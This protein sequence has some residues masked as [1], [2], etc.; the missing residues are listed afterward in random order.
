MENHNIKLFDQISSQWR[1]NIPK[2]NYIIAKEIIE[3]LHITKDQS[4]LDV[5]CGT[6]ILYPIIKDTNISK[7]I[8]VD[9]SEKMIKEFLQFY[10]NADVRLMNFE[11]KIKFEETF[12][13]IIIFNS[14]PHF[15]D[16]NSVFE[17]AY[18]NLKPHGKFII[19][20]C[21]TREDLKEHHK[22]IGYTSIDPI[23]K[24]DTLNKLCNKY[25]FKEMKIH[26][27]NYFYFCCKK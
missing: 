18:N 2:K 10:P 25:N 12:D 8:A 23:P 11:N 16:L 22:L 9:I 20:H 7:Y 21:R 4:I 19:A 27:I 14:I 17:N 13:Y 6:G 15:Y 5:G 24:D 1:K 3:S 26:D